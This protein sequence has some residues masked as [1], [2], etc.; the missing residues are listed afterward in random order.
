MLKDKYSIPKPA[1]DGFTLS[2]FGILATAIKKRVNMTDD[3]LMI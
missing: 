1:S 2:Y 3:A